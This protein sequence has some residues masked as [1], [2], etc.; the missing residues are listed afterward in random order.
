MVIAKSTVCI[1]DADPAIR[2][3]LEVLVDLGDKSVRSFSSIHAFMGSLDTVDVKCLLCAAELPDGNGIELFMRLMC[4]RAHFPFALLISENML[5][6]H[7]RALAAGIVNV[8]R[9]PI[10]D[11]KP[12]LNFIYQA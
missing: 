4:M 2:D 6:T 3:S 12:L 7:Q 8:F 1:L 10:A 11:P 5:M 9:K